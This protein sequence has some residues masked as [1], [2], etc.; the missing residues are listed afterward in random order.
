MLSA[1][2]YHEEPEGAGWELSR[3]L[4]DDLSVSVVWNWQLRLP[5][6]VLCKRLGMGLVA[7][8]LHCW[9]IDVSETRMDESPDDWTELE[10]ERCSLLLSASER[11]SQS[12]HS[13]AQR[14]AD[15]TTQGRCD[16]GLQKME[17]SLP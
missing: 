2:S 12:G 15:V 14:F 7:E 6:H 8:C 3:A 10:Q 16:V 4:I 13:D 17:I 11:D 1:A 5:H 9:L